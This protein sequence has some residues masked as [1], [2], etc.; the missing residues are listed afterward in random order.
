MG[1]EE[2]PFRC[3]FCKDIIEV[4]KVG[5]R[6]IITNFSGGIAEYEHWRCYQQQLFTKVLQNI[7]GE[8]I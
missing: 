1:T 3:R 5:E 4:N 8:Y 6:Y 2:A 7:F